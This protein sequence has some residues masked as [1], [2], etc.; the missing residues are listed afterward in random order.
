M[1]ESERFCGADISDSRSKLRWSPLDLC[2]CFR[3]WAIL[4]GVQVAQRQQRSGS[5][6]KRGSGNWPSY[7]DGSD[8]AT[9]FSIGSRR[10]WIRL[11]VWLRRCSQNPLPCESVVLSKSHIDRGFHG[12]CV[13]RY[14]GKVMDVHLGVLGA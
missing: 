4:G 5:G 11:L 13:S 9:A 7:R 6:G 1:L 14:A 12:L 2:A 8:R 3:T 10:D